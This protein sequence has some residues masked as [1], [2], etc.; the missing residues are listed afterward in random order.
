V[1]TAEQNI[2]GLNATI[3]QKV[4]QTDYNGNTIVSMMNQTATTIQLLAENIELSGITTV[5]DRL[6]IGS[7]SDYSTEK[8]LSFRNGAYINS[9]ANTDSIE[10]SSIGGYVFM[11]G[12]TKFGSYY[13]GGSHTV[14]FG[15]ATIL[16]L[17]TNDVAGLSS[18]SVGYASNAGQLGGLNPSQYSESG[19]VHS[20]NQY[21]KPSSGQA[22]ELGVSTATKKI[23]VYVSG[24]LVGQLTY[25]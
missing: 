16:N 21:V 4:S 10:I 22:I 8:N 17:N 9:P 7:K 11:S 13:G 5:A 12:V 23:N 2:N 19:H 1:N 3:T 20:S 14:D 25:V 18:A 15:N 6:S 24:G